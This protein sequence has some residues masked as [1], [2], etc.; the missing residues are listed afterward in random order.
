LTGRLAWSANGRRA[1]NYS[2]AEVQ[3]QALLA[4]SGKILGQPTLF[5]YLP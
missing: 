3:Q 4:A 2:Q 5:D 1:S